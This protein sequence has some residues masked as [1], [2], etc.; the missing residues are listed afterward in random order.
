MRGLS[1]AGSI[2]V[3]LNLLHICVWNSTLTASER[4][5]YICKSAFS[6]CKVGM[7]RG[8]KAHIIT[9]WLSAFHQ[10]IE[11]TD[12][13]YVIES[14]EGVFLWGWGVGVDI[15]YWGLNPRKQHVAPVDVL[16]SSRH[17]HYFCHRFYVTRDSILM[18]DRNKKKGCCWR[19][20]RWDKD[21]SKTRIDF[22]KG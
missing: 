10:T 13:E 9:T 3:L 4:Q 5:V 7:F 19:G 12:M 21:K 6:G 20:L 16:S 11:V 22:R 15:S 1:G 18:Q 2:Y 17:G 8:G 14:L